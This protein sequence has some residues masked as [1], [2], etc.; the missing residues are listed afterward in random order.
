MRYIPACA[1]V[2]STLRVNTTC[3]NKFILRN[4]SLIIPSC[5][6][7]QSELQ[8]TVIKS[9]E[10]FEQFRREFA[11]SYADVP[12]NE[13]SFREFLSD[14]NTN[15]EAGNNLK[16]YRKRRLDPKTQSNC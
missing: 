8:T 3:E 6:K 9:D 14:A 7:D 10:N 2:R 15:T 4:L 11:E 1:L 5:S 16:S 13:C 12:S